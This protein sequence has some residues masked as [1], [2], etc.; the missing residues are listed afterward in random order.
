MLVFSTLLFSLC[1]AGNELSAKENFNSELFLSKAESLS[2]SVNSFQLAKA[3]FL[4]DTKDDLGFSGRDAASSG[5]G[6]GDVCKD[7][8]LSQCP[9]NGT[10]SSCVTNFNRKKLTGCKSGYKISGNT[11]VPSTCATLNSGYAASMPSNSVC[12]KVSQYGLTCYS[13]CRNISCG[14]YPVNCPA[15]MTGDSYTANGITYQSCPDCPASASPS[16][17]TVYSCTIRKCKITSCPSTQKLNSAGTACINKDDTC[18]T[19]YYKSCETG[20]QGD[21]KYTELGTACYQCKPNTPPP[22]AIGDIL[23][24]DMTTSSEIISGKTPIGVVFNGEKRL[25]VGLH[26]FTH[27]HQFDYG[28]FSS[29]WIESTIDISQLSNKSQKTDAL[30]DWNG[31]DNTQK[32]V[33]Y[34]NSAKLKC[35]AFDYVNSYTTE[36]TVT[37]DW[38]IPALGEINDMC[39]KISILN[40]R[41]QLV[42]GDVIDMG[43]KWSSTEKD[44]YDAWAPFVNE[45]GSYYISA[46]TKN[47][48][49]VTI[50]IINY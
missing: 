3:T 23:Y 14:S 26:Q 10:C 7:Y 38:Y 41:L 6:Q 15:E 33:A 24:S 25:A 13:N 47:W 18:P 49:R 42:G 39:G 35:P 12:I 9:A 30:A 31:R 22:P 21:P 29:Q 4:P 45:D 20:T 36:G 34:C 2:T 48:V 44:Q 50:P 1:S 8:P 32:V 27:G 28:T 19:N 40:P 43:G 11:C 46:H 5:Y 17:T 37:G 16:S